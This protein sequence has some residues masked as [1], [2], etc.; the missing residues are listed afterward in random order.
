MYLGLFGLSDPYILTWSKVVHNA[1]TSI[2]YLGYYW[3]L[4]PISLLLII[5]LPF[6][7]LGFVLDRII[8]P[9]L[10]EM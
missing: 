2:A 10:R 7:L 6:A 5:G 4:K 3:I 9:R 1:L 8:N